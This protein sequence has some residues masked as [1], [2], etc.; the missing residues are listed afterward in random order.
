MPFAPGHFQQTVPRPKRS[1][2]RSRREQVAVRGAA[3]VTL[4]LVAL[5]VFSLTNHQRHSGHGCIDFSYST[6]IGGSEVYKCGAPARA[7]CATPPSGRSIDT[8]FQ[9]QLFAACRKA[10][11]P[12]GR[13]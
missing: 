3:I 13:S 4:V 7:L 1:R 11:I 10:G 9:T 2:Y 8:D 6:M 12:T 5:V